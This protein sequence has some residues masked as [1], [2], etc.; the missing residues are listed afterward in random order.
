MIEYFLNGWQENK[1]LLHE[2]EAQL[3]LAYVVC[4]NVNKPL[5]SIL[6]TLPSCFN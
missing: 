1:I 3:G 6:S 4:I 5:I 2:E